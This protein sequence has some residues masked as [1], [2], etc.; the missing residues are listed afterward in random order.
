MAIK[1]FKEGHSPKCLLLWAFCVIFDSRGKIIESDYIQ[2]S[3]V[4][5][6][7]FSKTILRACEWLEGL[8][9]IRTTV[10]LTAKGYGLKTSK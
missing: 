7:G 3:H 1:E 2:R 6:G 10:I 8:T 5:G 4:G 9:G